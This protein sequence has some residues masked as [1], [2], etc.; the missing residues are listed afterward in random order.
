M[1]A[2]GYTLF[3]Y[4]SYETTRRCSEL[5][6]PVS[7]CPLM[8]SLF[9]SWAVKWKISH[10]APWVIWLLVTFQLWPWW[11]G[12]VI[13]GLLYEFMIQAMENWA[14]GLSWWIQTNTTINFF[15]TCEVFFV[16]VFFF[17]PLMLFSS[18]FLEG[19]IT[20]GNIR[21]LDADI[22]VIFPNIWEA[23]IDFL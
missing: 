14:L 20:V 6:F 9:H 11:L 13:C 21:C 15:C 23:D 1:P 3:L 2:L 19:N 8:A 7:W 17:F 22:W 4:M 10:F 12:T 5:N 18:H 16:C